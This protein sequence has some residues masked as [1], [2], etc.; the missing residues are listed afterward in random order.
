M[1]RN[2][3][4][5]WAEDARR[6]KKACIPREISFKT[7]PEMALEQIRQAIAAGVP[8]G[9]VLTDASYGSNSAFR[10]GLSAVGLKYVVAI[11]PTIMV[12]S[13]TDDGEL[14]PR[15]SV[16]TLAR[17]PPKKAWRTDHLARGN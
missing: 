17:G 12:R 5:E 7:R 9:T 8:Q 3:P 1:G 15:L 16:K 10:T 6:R 4:Q 14:G 2:L 11:I 13:V